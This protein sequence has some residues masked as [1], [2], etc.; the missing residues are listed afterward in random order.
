LTDSLFR[1]EALAAVGESD[2]GAPFIE[3]PLTLSR[4]S[5]GVA[6]TMGILALIS[7]ILPVQDRRY[8]A[9]RVEPVKGLIQVHAERAGVVTGRSLEVGE[10]V[11]QG[12]AL[13]EVLAEAHSRANGGSSTSAAAAASEKLDSLRLSSE[14][15]SEQRQARTER[16]NVLLGKNIAE[17]AAI[18]GKA[19]VSLQLATVKAEQLE[20]AKSLATSGYVS[21]DFVSGRQTEM[22]EAKLRLADLQE[23]QQ[24][25]RLEI[26]ESQ[27]QLKQ[28]A[29]VQAEERRQLDRAVL[30]Q[31]EA[32]GDRIDA[33]TF[34]VK[35]PL[36]GYISSVGFRPGQYVDSAQALA[37]IVP[38]DSMMWCVLLVSARELAFLKAGQRVSLRYVAFPHQFFGEF[39]GVIR[40]LD[41]APYRTS[42]GDGS[43]MYR[44]YVEPVDQV[45]K[46]TNGPKPIVPGMELDAVVWLDER[47][48][49]S[50]LIRP[51]A[52]A[53]ALRNGDAR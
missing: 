5:L 21:K 46:T 13:A 25:L 15:A 19:A 4:L 30:D 2:G 43:S 27:I 36:D 7:C 20:R 8:V 53:I 26:E 52:Q 38:E 31:V 44:V 28:E 12:E 32:E 22:L 45:V 10:R 3:Y 16:L 18:R 40:R 33:I 17:L 9:G 50:W 29:A 23:R 34:S 39:P 6:L 14:K 35:S 11:K 1:K 41:N 48:L 51:V 47:S 42:D 49:A 37:T 24:Q